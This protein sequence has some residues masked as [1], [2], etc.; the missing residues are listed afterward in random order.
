[1]QNLTSPF[2]LPSFNVC[3]MFLS[4]LTLCNTSSLSTRSVQLIFSSLLQ[5]NVS[6]F[7]RCRLRK[8]TSRSKHEMPT[9]RHILGMWVGS[10]AAV[11]NGLS[12][13]CTQIVAHVQFL[14]VQSTVQI[15]LVHT[16]LNFVSPS[17]SMGSVHT[18][19]LLCHNVWQRV[20][21]SN[22]R[23]FCSTLLC[24]FL[25]QMAR[26][27]TSRYWEQK[28]PK[29]VLVLQVTSDA[30]KVSHKLLPPSS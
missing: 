2:S 7:F 28:R 30:G 17:D 16:D 13:T 21:S 5:H 20:G 4:S 29:L 25:S 23:I 27:V 10:V 22:W 1:M 8:Q 12:V 9:G 15:L 24:P 18:C 26:I 3:R 14:V 19:Q 6:K 11:L